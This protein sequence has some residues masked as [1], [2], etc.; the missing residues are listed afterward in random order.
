VLSLDS[1]GER[2]GLV[3]NILDLQKLLVGC[4]QLG[5]GHSICLLAMELIISI[6]RL[7]I[8]FTS[9]VE[10]IRSTSTFCYEIVH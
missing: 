3:L 9:I 4:S 7:F 2:R 6:I 1:L 5:V 8:Y 10:A